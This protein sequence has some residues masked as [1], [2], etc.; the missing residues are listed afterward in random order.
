[1]R[2]PCV[3][4]LLTRA[5][6]F[7]AWV[8]CFR[9][10]VCLPSCSLAKGAEEGRV[11]RRVAGETP[12]MFRVS[13]TSAFV[14]RSRHQ[15][16]HATAR[17]IPVSLPT[18][19]I[20]R[21]TVARLRG[22]FDDYRRRSQHCEFKASRVT[23]PWFSFLFLVTFVRV[24]PWIYF[25]IRGNRADSGRSSIFSNCTASHESFCTFGVSHW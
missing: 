14:R 18:H 4:N 13:V 11:K 21:S 19:P 17:I 25:S 6:G 9:C 22:G 15:G 23:S 8:V 5:R 12:S 2:I 1:M 3:K 24:L 16:R 10:A 20:I 7:S